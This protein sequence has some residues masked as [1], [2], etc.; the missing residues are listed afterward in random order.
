MPDCSCVPGVSA[1]CE[2]VRAAIE[3]SAIAARAVSVGLVATRFG[4]L[5]SA[6]NARAVAD[7]LMRDASIDTEPVNAARRK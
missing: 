6:T 7:T 2:C 4:R 1:R 3:A 5:A